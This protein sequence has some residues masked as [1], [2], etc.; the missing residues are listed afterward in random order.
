MDENN[1]QNQAP[2]NP[3]NNQPAVP[4]LMPTPPA[5]LPLTPE[6]TSAP[7]EMASVVQDITPLP[8]PPSQTPPPASS[9]ISLNVDINEP[10]SS[11]SPISEPVSLPDAPKS[12]FTSLAPG[13]TTT[14][15]TTTTSTDEKTG[16]VL[17]PKKK[18]SKALPIIV[19]AFAVLV[20]GGI[21]GASYF[22][23]NRLSQQASVAPN[24]PESNPYAGG[25]CTPGDRVTPPA[26][27][28]CSELPTFGWDGCENGTLCCCS[29]GSGSSSGGPA[30]S[31]DSTK[32]DAPNTKTITFSKAGSVILF[33][34]NTTGTVTLSG[35]KTVTIA[36]AGGVAT[37]QTT[38]FSV[39]AGETYN[40]TVRLSGENKDAYGWRPNKSAS[41]CGPTDA[42]CGGDA[43]IDPV[44]N[45]A[46]A[47]SDQAGI[48]AS[49][50]SNIMCWGDAEI[51]D[52]TQDYDYNDFTLIF[53]YEKQTLSTVPNCT[54]ITGPSTLTV[55]EKGTYTATFTQ[56]QSGG[57]TDGEIFYS[58]TVSEVDQKN[59][60]T[61]TPPSKKG[62]ANNG[63][64]SGDFTPTEPGKYWLRCRA[65][66]DGIAE[67]RP[68]A[69]VATAPTN[70]NISACTGPGYEKLVTVVAAVAGPSCTVANLAYKEEATG[71][72]IKITD[73][74]QIP[75]KIK[76]GDT[77]RLYTKGSGSVTKARFRVT[78][79]NATQLFTP[80]WK[81][82]VVD[83]ANDGAGSF[84]VEFTIT[85]PGSYTFEAEVQ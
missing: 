59:I 45:L 60:L 53:G 31:C 21:A 24:A 71:R 37:Q 20:I 61:T 22:V 49:G 30:P 29:T 3:L 51:G 79:P 75:A 18:K 38:K 46:A 39:N 84:Y 56:S 64:V 68:P 41:I 36:S 77:V 69:T 81:D 26:S 19:A 65:W 54:N 7:Q 62:V 12:P 67:C 52:A 70:P 9:P 47:N 55:G 82:G 33:T 42:I 44:K 27:G 4:P 80:E 50:G 72:W 32:R 14:T 76:A 74:T 28:N 10:T 66:N 85:N 6:M 8:T 48:T 5:P 1:Q 57:L 23:S 11:P 15:T 63:V 73:N 83:D 43:N 58:T 25:L 16:D 17:M 35:P 78:Q 40:I 13:T 34:R 2:N